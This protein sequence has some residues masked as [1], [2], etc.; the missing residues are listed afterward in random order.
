MKRFFLALV[1]FLTPCTTTTSAQE[2]VKPLPLWLERAQVETG[3][4]ADLAFN[5]TKFDQAVL[6]GQLGEQWWQ[7]DKV[8]ARECWKKAV[9]IA[10]FVPLQETAAERKAR[11][12][13]VRSLLRHIGG[14]DRQLSQR[15]TEALKTLAEQPAEGTSREEVGKVLLDTAWTLAIEEPQRAK[16]LALSGLQAGGKLGVSLLI[17]LRVKDAQIADAFFTE[18]LAMARAT[19]ND[20]LLSVLIL[21]PFALEERPDFSYPHTPEALRLRALN[22]VIERLFLLPN[23]AEEKERY[24]QFIYNNVA[25][26][27][28]PLQGYFPERLPL[29]QQSLDTCQNAFN[30]DSIEGRAMAQAAAGQKL[31]DNPEELFP[32]MPKTV[33]EMLALARRTRDLKT[34]AAILWQ[35]SHKAA[36]QK[37]YVQAISILEGMTPEERPPYWGVWRANFAAMAAQQH[38]KQK[39]YAEARKVLDAVPVNLAA[40]ALIAGLRGL[41]GAGGHASNL[42]KGREREF[43]ED[44]QVLLT[45]WLTEARKRLPQIESGVA[46]NAE[47]YQL[48]LV[49]LYATLAPAEAL[50]VL[51]EAVR[52]MNQEYTKAEGQKKKAQEPQEEFGIRTPIELLPSFVK[53]SFDGIRGA[54]N[55][56]DSKDTCIRLRLG[57]LSAALAFQQ[58]ESKTKKNREE[59]AKEAEKKRPQTKP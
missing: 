34:R 19:R 11:L 2:P 4:I 59:A 43:S 31:P 8:R 3:L 48:A 46:G 18:A 38:F 57:L 44:E 24:C 17:K 21:V 20:E 26:Y 6:Y 47:S 52:A 25:A 37:D 15:L 14:H 9:E 35:A 29:V 27:R 50:P 51:H 49:N 36:G 23:T 22:A 12:Q 55:E 58:E 40:M 7:T 41:V 13:T 30:H 16:E 5:F 28:E 39:D 53:E 33:E 42:A 54:L 56:L 1:I 32:E 10:A 45:E